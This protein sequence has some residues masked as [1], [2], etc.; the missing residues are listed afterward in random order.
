MPDILLGV[1]VGF[2]P[3]VFVVLVSVLLAQLVARQ[4]K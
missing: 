3:I 4:R 2:V 1:S